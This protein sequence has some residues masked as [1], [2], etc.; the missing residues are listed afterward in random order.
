MFIYA[1][2]KTSHVSKTIYVKSHDPCQHQLSFNL[3]L[4]SCSDRLKN[5]NLTQ[6]CICF[7]LDL[8]VL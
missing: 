1:N 7:V 5:N 6:Q 2:L 8:R 4:L 3:D